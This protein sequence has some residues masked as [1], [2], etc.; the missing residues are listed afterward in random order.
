[1]DG[2]PRPPTLRDTWPVDLISDCALD[3]WEKSPSVPRAE[4]A[5][6]KQGRRRCLTQT[7]S[8]RRGWAPG[9]GG[10]L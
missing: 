9:D 4:A 6:W 3:A 5:M 10:D 2:G 7:G 1:M 8:E